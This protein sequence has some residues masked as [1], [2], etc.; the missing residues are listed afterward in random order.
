MREQ[1]MEFLEAQGFLFLEFIEEESSEDSF[2]FYGETD[3]GF[4]LEFKC[5]AQDGYVWDRSRGN[6]YWD[7]TGKVE[8]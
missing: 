1:F 8:I 6:K 3:K 4:F 2:V 5:N 7:I